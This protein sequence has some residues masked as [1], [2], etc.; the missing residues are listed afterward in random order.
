MKEKRNPAARRNRGAAANHIDTRVNDLLAK[1]EALIR[2]IDQRAVQPYEVDM[3]TAYRKI[4]SDAA[5]LFFSP[6]K[7]KAIIRQ[8]LQKIEIAGNNV[9]MTFSGNFLLCCAQNVS[10]TGGATQT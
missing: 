5:A 1:R 2:K 4:R 7:S 3:D 9:E 8:Y 10:A 6:Q